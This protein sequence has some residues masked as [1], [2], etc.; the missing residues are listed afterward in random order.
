MSFG[1][2]AGDESG[3]VQGYNAVGAAMRLLMASGGLQS[4]TRT[5]TRAADGSLVMHVDRSTHG[6]IIGLPYGHD[7]STWVSWTVDDTASA[8]GDAAAAAAPS[9][10]VANVRPFK[11]HPFA[12]V[13]LV[14]IDSGPDNDEALIASLIATNDVTK[15]WDIAQTAEPGPHWLEFHRWHDPRIRYGTMVQLQAGHS[16]R[17]AEAPPD[18]AVGSTAAATQL[19]WRELVL[20]DSTP[21]AETL[22]TRTRAL[23]GSGVRRCQQDADCGSEACARPLASA[24]GFCGVTTSP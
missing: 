1:E 22:K 6:L 7:F 19:S 5:F 16:Y 21:G 9:A 15:F 14:S 3:F 10:L 24:W 13:W 12:S 11:A 18:C 20:E 4:L 2:E 8:A 17:L 23:C